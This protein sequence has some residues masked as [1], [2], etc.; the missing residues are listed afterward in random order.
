MQRIGWIVALLIAAGWI[1]SEIPAGYSDGNAGAASTW[2]RTVQGWQHRNQVV[3]SQPLT[4]RPLG[5]LVVA[6]LEL[7]LSGLALLAFSPAPS[8]QRREPPRMGQ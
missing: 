5:P 6:G 7:L 8:V 1:A 4:A 2:R 3:S